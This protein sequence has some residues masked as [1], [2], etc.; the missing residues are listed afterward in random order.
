MILKS[1]F[2][3]LPARPVNYFEHFA[4]FLEVVRRHVFRSCYL[5]PRLSSCSRVPIACSH[6]LVLTKE[7]AE[8]DHRQAIVAPLL[9]FCY[10]SR[11]L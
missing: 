5:A 11:L 7:A 10:A 8:V 4:C 9:H 3:T 1:V 2:V 6:G